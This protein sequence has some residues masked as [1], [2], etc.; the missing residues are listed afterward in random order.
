MVLRLAVTAVLIDH[1]LVMNRRTDTGRQ[2]I[3][4]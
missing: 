2:H 1:R 3:P 4:R